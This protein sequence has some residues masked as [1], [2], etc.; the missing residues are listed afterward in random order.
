M[1]TIQGRDHNTVVL[2]CDRTRRAAIGVAT[3]DRVEVMKS[4]ILQNSCPGSGSLLLATEEK[5]VGVTRGDKGA[6]AEKR[7]RPLIYV[8]ESDHG[9]S[10]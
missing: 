5:D 9:V 8:L 1:L 6:E 4:K 3:K 2:K 10:G 7:S